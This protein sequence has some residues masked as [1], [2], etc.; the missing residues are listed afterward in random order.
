MPEITRALR[1]LQD[2]SESLKVEMQTFKT[3]K[4]EALE[5]FR[6][7]QDKWRRERQ[8]EAEEK[9]AA[10]EQKRKEAGRR[11]P[12]KRRPGRP[13]PPRRCSRRRR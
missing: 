2:E 5:S 9:A 10:L 6:A 4:V 11:S 1:K 12:W 13:R 7:E 8:K 3:R